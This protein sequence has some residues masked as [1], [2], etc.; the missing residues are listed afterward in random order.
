MNAVQFHD[1]VSQ[2]LKHTAYNPVFPR[3]NFDSYFAGRFSVFHVFRF[4]RL[5][6]SVLEPV[7]RG[8]K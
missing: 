7:A 2:F 5:N 3:V 4:I 8:Q 6:P 1:F